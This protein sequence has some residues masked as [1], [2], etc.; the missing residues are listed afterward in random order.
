MQGF[1][2]SHLHPQLTTPTINALSSMPEMLA[3]S[4]AVGKP[5]VGVIRRY[6]FF[7]CLYMAD[8]PGRLLVSRGRES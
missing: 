2:I 4:M 1:S 8:E 5:G 6:L 3:D 7:A